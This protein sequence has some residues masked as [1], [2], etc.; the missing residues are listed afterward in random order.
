MI[1]ENA[2]K[3]Y[4][5]VKAQTAAGNHVTANDIADATD[6]SVKSVHP[7]IT[8]SLGEKKDRKTGE[9]VRPALVKRVPA[10]IET[11][12]GEA[13]VKFIE[14]TDFGMTFDINA[15]DDAE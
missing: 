10:V 7:L 6:I 3:V 2:K 9:V 11:E 4:N 13:Q 14:M 5:Y 1:S 12:N 15:E 8:F